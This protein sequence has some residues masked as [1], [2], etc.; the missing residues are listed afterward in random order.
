MQITVLQI[1]QQD[2]KNELG[3]YNSLSLFDWCITHLFSSI[4]VFTPNPILFSLSLHM[5][6]I[7]IADS[8]IKGIYTFKQT[9]KLL[10]WK[11]VAIEEFEYDALVFYFRRVDF[12]LQNKF[13]LLH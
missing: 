1:N 5:S 11:P 13:R 12:S 9:L 3:I 2:L 7:L 4:F 6:G 10:D 8:D